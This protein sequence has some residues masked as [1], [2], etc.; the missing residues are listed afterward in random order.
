SARVD[1]N[2]QHSAG[3]VPKFVGEPNLRKDVAVGVENLNLVEDILAAAH[4][5]RKVYREPEKVGGENIRAG[6]DLRNRRQRAAIAKGGL[7]I[8]GND[9]TID[10]TESG[11]IGFARFHAIARTE[12]QLRGI[13]LVGAKYRGPESVRLRID[14]REAQPR[15]AL[16]AGQHAGRD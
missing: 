13:A 3:F 6:V 15:F 9:R 8:F 1:V 7:V 4:R 2:N 14:D 10:G 16:L 11:S 5:L 12:Y